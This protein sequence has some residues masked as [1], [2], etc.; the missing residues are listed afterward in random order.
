M[1]IGSSRPIYIYKRVTSFCSSVSTIISLLRVTTGTLALRSTGL[2]YSVYPVGHRKSDERLWRKASLHLRLWYVL[3]SVSIRILFLA[4]QQW[5]RTTAPCTVTRVMSQDRRAV[6]LCPRLV[7]GV[8]NVEYN[9]HQAPVECQSL[10]NTRQP[11]LHNIDPHFLLFPCFVIS[12]RY[13]PSADTLRSFVD[14]SAT[15]RHLHEIDDPHLA[16][17]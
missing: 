6:A 9:G 16:R 17:G 5:S 12:P 14:K 8:S 15:D 2:I 4:F 1:I 11:V 3:V 13:L 7:P 10:P